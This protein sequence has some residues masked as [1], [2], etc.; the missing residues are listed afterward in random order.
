MGAAW[1]LALVLHG[2]A[3]LVTGVAGQVEWQTGWVLALAPWLVV[4]VAAHAKHTDKV[5]QQPRTHGNKKYLKN[6]ANS[7]KSLSHTVLK[8]S[9]KSVQGLA[10]KT[11]EDQ[12]FINFTIQTS[13]PHT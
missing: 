10:T 5:S 11:T 4:E 9:E 13:A 6:S 8:F 12:Y 2:I 1:A 7:L 3:S